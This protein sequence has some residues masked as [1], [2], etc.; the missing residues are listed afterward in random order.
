MK[1]Q[2]EG[3]SFSGD[4]VAVVVGDLG[5]HDA[6]MNGRCHLHHLQASALASQLCSCHPCIMLCLWQCLTDASD[7]VV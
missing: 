7:A 5:A 3:I 4:L 2:D 6:V 1:G